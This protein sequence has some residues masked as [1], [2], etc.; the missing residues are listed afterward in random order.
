MTNIKVI[1]QKLCKYLDPILTFNEL[2]DIVEKQET[3]LND[4]RIIENAMNQPDLSNVLVELCNEYRMCRESDVIGVY[5]ETW[6]E[7][8]Q[9]INPEQFSVF[10]YALIANINSNRFS[11]C[12]TIALLA[13]RCYCLCQTSP[14]SKAFGFFNEN[15]FEKCFDLLKN[16]GS[17]AARTTSQSYE[18]TERQINCITFLEDIEIFLGIV[19]L[20]GY[21]DVKHALIENMTTV[22]GF[23][24]V[25]S[26][27]RAPLVVE[28]CLRVLESLIQ[29][30]QGDIKANLLLI[31]NGTISLNRRHKLD[32]SSMGT[33]SEMNSI[34][35][36]FI[37]LLDKYP[38]QTCAVL[39]AFIK[40]VLTIPGLSGDSYDRLRNIDICVQ[41]DSAMYTK[42]NR[43]IVDYLKDLAS[44]TVTYDRE[45]CMEM[46]GKMLLVDSLPC[47]WS[48]SSKTV[49]REIDLL[50]L[51]VAKFLDSNVI[52]V[53]AV[54]LFLKV[55]QM[56]NTMSKRILQSFMPIDNSEES[57]NESLDVPGIEELN[58]LPN[59]LFEIAQWNMRNISALVRRSALI[60]LEYVA[61]LSVGIEEF[62]SSKPFEK[63]VEDASPMVRRQI[64]STLETI[65]HIKSKEILVCKSYVKAMMFLSNDSDP[66]VVDDVMD[67][68][69]KNIFDNIDK[70]EE[71]AS[72]RKLFPWKLLRLIIALG[73]ESL[74][75][76]KCIEKSI[77]RNLMTSR[78]LQYLETYLNS[79]YSL[80]A[81]ILLS[82]VA[83]NIKSQTPQFVFFKLQENLRDFGHETPTKAFYQLDVVQ[84]WFDHFPR[85]SQIDLFS[86]F[87]TLLEAGK[88]SPMHVK[89]IYDMC[90]KYAKRTGELEQWTKQMKT[91][92]E[93]YILKNCKLEMASSS[94]DHQLISYLVIYSETIDEPTQINRNITNYLFN[95]LHVELP[96][97]INVDPNITSKV[98]VMQIVLTRLAFCDEEILTK[99]VPMLVAV[100]N[101]KGLTD[102]VCETAIKCLGDLC[103]KY[104]QLVE[105]VISSVYM[106]TQSI[107]EQVRNC[108]IETLAILVLDDYLKFRGSL[109][110][111]VL[112]ATAD[113]KD[114]IAQL[115]HEL[116]IKFANEKNAILIQSCLRECPF[117][118][119]DFKIFDHSELFGSDPLLR[120]P[121]KARCNARRYIYRFLVHNLEVINC[122][123]YFEHFSTINDYLSKKGF[124]KTTELIQSVHD[125]LYIC[126][127][128]CKSKNM[129]KSE[130]SMPSDEATA[131]PTTSKRSRQHTTLPQAIVVVE[132]SISR[133]PELS[134]SL[135][136][137]DANF[138]EKFNRI[139]VAIC[140]HFGDSIKY[141][142]NLFWDKYRKK[143]PMKP[144][145]KPVGRK[146]DVDE[147]GISSSKVQKMPRKSEQRHSEVRKCSVRVT[148]NN[149]RKRAISLVI[150]DSESDEE[151]S[152]SRT[153]EAHT[154]RLRTNQASKRM[155]IDDSDSDEHSAMVTKSV[156]VSLNRLSLN[157]T[158]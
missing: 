15:I 87:T 55:T 149:S 154:K 29:P 42:C 84:K 106:K 91:K 112:A 43:S 151:A 86:K 20:D 124:Q 150:N 104:T 2:D 103:K 46:V 70:Y 52:K 49:P 37:S 113:P 152:T 148:S 82:M 123:M 146:D 95:F 60:L 85:Q 30:L 3:Q 81:W 125:F 110:L 83:S 141:F 13:A 120:S 108:A 24:Y 137:L 143:K 135:I 58:D 93:S 134:A 25:N 71:T 45:S 31:L 144:P 117:T 147:C 140:E 54:N 75:L 72:E 32:A 100:L 88:V 126:E 65:L 26:L 158:N 98:N 102:N 64:V 59:K 18:Q 1:L 35:N 97:K 28:K 67:S 94:Y 63:I 33:S 157:I 122:Y 7:F 121:L 8:S 80:D 115:A 127:H 6:D 34:V 89:R 57:S 107:S 14:G 5:V 40:H 47:S 129:P 10:L 21:L 96:K 74:D 22:L 11:K 68:L 156:R 155:V 16:L 131:E 153:S 78:T 50:S 145:M 109:L 51:L 76:R 66:K 92:C 48:T 90:Y 101:R 12:K 133:F 73:E 61:T 79:S 38:K 136:E 4:L 130:R 56:G 116:I 111:Y 44:S 9:F 118:F 139:C 27:P 99:C 132:K 128:I 39:T 77:N 69:R 36:W 19:S 62:L 138:K 17:G 105:S 142:P 41:Y 114:N 119:N 23:H 53:K